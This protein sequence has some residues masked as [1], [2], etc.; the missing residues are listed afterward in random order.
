MTSTSHTEVVT[1]DARFFLITY[2]DGLEEKL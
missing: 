1:G 2:R